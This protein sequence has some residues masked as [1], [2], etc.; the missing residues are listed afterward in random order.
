MPRKFYI[1]THKGITF[2]VI[3]GMMALFN[4]WQ[5]ATAWV[6]LALHGTYGVLWVLKSRIFP[7]KKWEQPVSIWR[8]VGYYWAGLT[9]YWIT[10][11]LLNS[12]AVQAPPWLLGMVISTCTLGIFLHYVS[13]MQKYIELKYNPG[14]LIT[15]G[16]VR[17]TRSINYF[18]ELLIYG[19]FALLAMH[20]LPF[21][22]L[23]SVVAVE[24]LPNM[25][26]KD[27]SL[28]RYPQFAEYEKNSRKFIPFLY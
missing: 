21:V 1:D 10:P 16:L 4:Q 18:G 7:D 6:Y 25:R 23:A 12:R 28:A 5:N 17:N 11:Y 19:A 3:L 26:R 14:T 22:I 24:W 2:L 9:L 8:G 15:D 20:W 13:D 27:A